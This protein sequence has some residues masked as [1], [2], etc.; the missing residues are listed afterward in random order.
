MFDFKSF[1]ENLSATLKAL[2]PKITVASPGAAGTLLYIHMRGWMLLPP[3]VIVSVLV[4]GIL[5]A[6]LAF[7]SLLASLGINERYASA[8]CAYVMPTACRNRNRKNDKDDGASSQSAWS[9]L[10]GN[11]KNTTER[12]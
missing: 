5:C 12:T 8:D 10:P 9:Y 6:C 4:V 3:V 2:T 1:T 11:N 7:T